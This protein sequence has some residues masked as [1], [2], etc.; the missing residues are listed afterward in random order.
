MVT[1]DFRL[2]L[3]VL[4]LVWMIADFTILLSYALLMRGG[5]FQ[6]HQRTISLL[7]SAFLLCIAVLGI[8]YTLMT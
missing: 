5:V 3:G 6:R 7:S 8:V 2:S 4:T 1:P